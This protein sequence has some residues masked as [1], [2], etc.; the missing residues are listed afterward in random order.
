VKVGDTTA[1]I[2]V[3]SSVVPTGKFSMTT[4]IIDADGSVTNSAAGGTSET[5][6][7]KKGDVKFNIEIENW[8]WCTTLTGCNGV[9]AFIDVVVQVKGTGT[10]ADWSTD[11][12]VGDLG[13]STLTLSSTVTV[14]GATVAMPAGYPLIGGNGNNK[15]TLTIRFPKFTTSAVYDPVLS[16]PSSL[17]AGYIVLIVAGSVIGVAGLYFAL[18]A[19]GCLGSK[20]GLAANKDKDKDKS[21]SMTGHI[22]I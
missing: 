3:F 8:V 1:S 19:Y 9:G 14:D 22:N 6:T 11:G 4:M 7:L 2:V 18:R 21:G 13:G 17:G 10:T 12:T 15:N 20:A 16:L 5:L